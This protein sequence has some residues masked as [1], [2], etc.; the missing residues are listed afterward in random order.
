M[1]SRGANLGLLSITITGE[2]LTVVIGSMLELLPI[3]TFG[4]GEMPKPATPATG[5]T[6]IGGSEFFFLS[7]V[8]S[9][10]F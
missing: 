4:S 7:A 2:W 10:A 9:N 3:I 5:E 8:I 6:F 1:G